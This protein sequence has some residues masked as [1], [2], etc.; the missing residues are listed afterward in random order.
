MLNCAILGY[1]NRGSIYADLLYKTEGVK[2]TAVCDVNPENLG[3]AKRKYGLEDKDCFSSDEEFFKVKRGDCVVI[4]TMDRLHVRHAVAALKTGYDVL[5]EKPI[6]TSL[7]DCE[8]I[9]RAVE[10]SGKKILVCHVLRYTAFFRKIK[11]LLTQGAIGDVVS[12]SEAEDVHFV[13]YWLSFLHGNWHSEENSSSIILQKCCHDFDIISWLIGKNCVTV[14]SMG[15][16]AVYKEENKPAGA[17]D[18]CCD[19]KYIDD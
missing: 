10:E 2:I 18:Y 12:V 8:H 17:A 15:N 14:S 11:E 6:A 7:K 19:C 13:H 9:E 5:L 1:G 4:A 16:L 3:I